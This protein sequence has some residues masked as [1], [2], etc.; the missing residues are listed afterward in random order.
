MAAA[1]FRCDAPV[2]AG[3]FTIPPF[4]LL[5]LP[6]TGTNGGVTFNG[7]FDIS[8]TLDKPFNASGLDIGVFSANAVYSVQPV[9]YK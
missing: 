5:T 9:T 8:N 7:I 2:E 6:P 3:E 1:G 4:V